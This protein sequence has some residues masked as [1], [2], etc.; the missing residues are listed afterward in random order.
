MGLKLFASVSADNKSRHKQ[1]KGY[2]FTF[3]KKK[4]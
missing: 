3:K 1:G 2:A 4:Y